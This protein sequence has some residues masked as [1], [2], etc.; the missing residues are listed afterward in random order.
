[1]NNGK[2]LES[3]QIESPN[4][5]LKP[6]KLFHLCSCVDMLILVYVLR[7]YSVALFHK[8]EQ[9]EMY[10]QTVKQMLVA[11]M[12]TDTHIRKNVR[13]LVRNAFISMMTCE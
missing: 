7:I 6:E 2:M 11:H 1:M 4:L 13:I 9:T 10:P 3:F 8:F 5:C 12:H